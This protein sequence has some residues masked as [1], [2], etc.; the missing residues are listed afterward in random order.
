[1]QASFSPNMATSQAWTQPPFLQQRRGRP[2]IRSCCVVFISLYKPAC[3]AFISRFPRPAAMRSISRDIPV[4]WDVGPFPFQ[5]SSSV[6]KENRFHPPSPPPPCFIPLK[7][8][9]SGKARKKKKKGKKRTA[10]RS[11]EH[12][13]RRHH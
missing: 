2:H 12:Q 1:M 10:K 4:P 7:G 6:S 11:G 3:L 13:Q 5:G 9:K 8:D